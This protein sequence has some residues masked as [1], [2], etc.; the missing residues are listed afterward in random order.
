MVTYIT[1][2]TSYEKLYHDIQN[3]VNVDSS[4]YNMVLKHQ[5]RENLLYSIP[6]LKVTSDIE[7]NCLFEL[8]KMQATPVFVTLVRKDDAEGRNEHSNGANDNVNDFWDTLEIAREDDTNIPETIVPHH[9]ITT[10]HII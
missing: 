6:P 3:K 7:V 8:N 2:I 5:F 10:T 9:D 1:E 4:R